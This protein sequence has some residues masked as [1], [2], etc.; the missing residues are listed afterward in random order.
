M[1]WAPLVYS[2]LIL[3]RDS[4]NYKIRIQAAEALVVSSTVLAYGS[5]LLDVVQGVEHILENLGSKQNLLSSNFKCKIALEKQQTSSGARTKH[6]PSAAQPWPPRKPQ[7]RPTHLMEP[8]IA[9]P[10][11]SGWPWPRRRRIRPT[12]PLSETN[13]PKTTHTQ[14]AT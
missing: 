3:L 9:T 11:S 10:S 7:P 4:P 14:I 2:I 6:I 13:S 1:G 5:L 8:D 12:T